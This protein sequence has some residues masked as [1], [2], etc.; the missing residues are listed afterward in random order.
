M[1]TYLSTLVPTN[2][3]MKNIK[4]QMLLYT[5]TKKFMEVQGCMFNLVGIIL[6]YKVMGWF[7]GQDI[8]VEP[9]KPKFN[10]LYQ[11]ILCGICIFI[12][13]PCTCV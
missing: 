12:Y 7:D 2:L 3:L 8:G 1:C 6:F 9:K 11:H 4:V 10:P 13:I 5:L